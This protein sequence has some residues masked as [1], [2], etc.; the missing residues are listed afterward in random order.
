M[1]AS[2]QGE[3]GPEAEQ[4]RIEALQTALQ[5]WPR[6]HLSVLDAIVGHLRS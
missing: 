1:G 2:A 3:Q 5:R 4:L 6:V